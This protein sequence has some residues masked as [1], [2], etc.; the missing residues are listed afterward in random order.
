MV[1]VVQRD[2]WSLPL[3][4]LSPINLQDFLRFSLKILKLPYFINGIVDFTVAVPI[5]CTF[6]F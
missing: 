5:L 4:R 6:H 3:N 1:V 2:T